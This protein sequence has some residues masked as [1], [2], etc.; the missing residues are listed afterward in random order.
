MFWLYDLAAAAVT[1]HQRTYNHQEPYWVLTQSPNHEA[2]TQCMKTWSR[3]FAGVEMEHQTW[4]I[5]DSDPEEDGLQQ[6]ETTLVALL[7]AKKRNMKLQLTQAHQSW[8]IEGSKNVA[9][10]DQSHF[11]LWHP[12]GQVG[13]CQ[14]C[15]GLRDHFLAYLE[16]LHTNWAS[17]KQ[18]GLPEYCCWAK[19]IQLWPQWTICWSSS[20]WVQWVHRTPKSLRNFFNTENISQK[21]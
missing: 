17:F 4:E 10:S 12:E 2:A 1:I 11:H 13:C 16:Q 14:W 7:S 19:S 9:W 8:T 21:N 20:I 3:Q 5:R 6:G 18:C 15:N